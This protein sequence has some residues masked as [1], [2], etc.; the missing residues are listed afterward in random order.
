V[1]TDYETR[2]R[3]QFSVRRWSGAESLR[4]QHP[5]AQ[6]RHV[7]VLQTSDEFQLD[8]AGAGDVE[9]P[10]AGPQE[11]RNEM[12]LQL[13]EF[14]RLEQCLCCAR[15]VDQHGAVTGGGGAAAAHVTTSEKYLVVLGSTSLSS[16]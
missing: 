14:A 4:A 11:H 8:A 10:A 13:V 12:D 1:R 3:F 15:T 6:V 5:V 2:W 7:A 16:T 9:Q